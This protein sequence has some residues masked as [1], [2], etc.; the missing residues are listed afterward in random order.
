[1]ASFRGREELLVPE[2]RPRG[3]QPYWRPRT[4]TLELLAAVDAVL[5][6]YADHLPVTI[7]QVFY[8]AVSDGVLPKTER[9]YRRLQETLGMARRAGRIPWEAIRDESGTAAVPAA[10]A[11][12]D[13]FRA[14]LRRATEGYRLDRQEGQPVRLEVWCEAAGMVPQ[15]AA[16]ADPYG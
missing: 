8:A 6:R 4:P 9:G 1:M 14:G 15:L 12:P 5:D 2:K 11:G 13:A 7:R 10:F 3:Y 16:I